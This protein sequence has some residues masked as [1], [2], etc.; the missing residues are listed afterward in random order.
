MIY[1][2]TLPPTPPEGYR[3]VYVIQVR[4]GAMA[5]KSNN[6]RNTVTLRED[7]IATRARENRINA[8]EF[9]RRRSPAQIFAARI[10]RPRRQT[11]Q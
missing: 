8:L 2:I 10:K 3:V 11:A 7:T 1:P 5:F 9:L 6:S 4:A